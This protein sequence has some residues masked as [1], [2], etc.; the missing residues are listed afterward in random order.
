MPNND[1]GTVDHQII[2]DGD[3]DK[4]SGRRT[5][6]V[7]APLQSINPTSND[8]TAKNSWPAKSDKAK[9]LIVDK[10]N[11]AATDGTTDTPYHSRYPFLDLEA[12]QGVFIPVK[13]GDTVDALV[14]RLHKDIYRTRE[15]LAE[16]EK[17]ENG[18]EIL[19]MLCVKERKRNADGTIQLGSDG[20]PITGA[21]FV[22]RPKLVSARHFTVRAVIKDYDLG[23]GK[24]APEDGAMVI[25]SM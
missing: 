19:E 21:N 14:E 11:L 25:R 12:D 24:K 18:D 23:G 22:Q 8:S 5:D 17:D 13:P 20:K 9:F 2:D 1:N 16:P 3:K 10:A 4:A 6:L 15:Y 7:H